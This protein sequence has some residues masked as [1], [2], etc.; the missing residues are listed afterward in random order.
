[1]GHHHLR[2]AAAARRQRANSYDLVCRRDACTVAVDLQ[3]EAVQRACRAVA[4]VQLVHRPAAHTLQLTLHRQPLALVR[5][6][7]D[8]QVC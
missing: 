8:R 3:H 5:S 4:E 7:D 2:A 1:M 6:K